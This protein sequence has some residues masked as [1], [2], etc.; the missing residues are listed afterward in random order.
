VLPPIGSS[1]SNNW[2][3]RFCVY[4][5]LKEATGETKGCG[6]FKDEVMDVGDGQA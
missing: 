2:G 1:F 5:V 3:H 4:V 6:F